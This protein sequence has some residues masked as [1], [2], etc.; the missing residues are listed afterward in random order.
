MSTYI[1]AEAGVNHNGSLEKAFQ[2]VDA[3]A[4]AKAD[5]IKFQ[6]FQA[7]E[8]ASKSA[9]LA[10]YQKESQNLVKSQVEM[11]SNLELT[12][13]EHAL[14]MQYCK[15]CGI[16]FLSSPF[17]IGSI[18]LLN[19]LGLNTYK[20][21]SGE[22][23]NLPYLRHIGRLKKSVILS[24]GM[25]NI[26][27]VDQALSVLITSGMCKK[28]ITLLHANT[29]Y[30]TP[31]SDVNLKAMLTMKSKFN[32]EIGY[33]DHTLGIEVPI[34][35]VSLGAK[36]IEKHFTLDK[37]SQGPDHKASL[38]QDE[39]LEMVNSIRNIELAMGDGIKKPS[40]SES[41]NI[42]VVRKSIVASTD[43]SCGERFTENN[44]SVKRPGTGISP[45][46]WDQLIGKRAKRNYKSDSLI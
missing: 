5:A 39:F 27:E 26:S 30:P 6:T 12:E 31:M 38:E 41:E 25:A 7:T 40:P 43:I 14:I 23:T 34:A 9:L 29:M 10:D 2:L 32:V 36:V 3:A 13:E 4:Y 18:D 44:L 21:P 20:I 35:A 22:I 33:S 24:T 15:S 8:L 42:T 19:R 46:E 1:I 16:D 45:M 28:D 37:T 11:L 17:D